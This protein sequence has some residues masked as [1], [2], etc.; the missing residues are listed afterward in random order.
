MRKTRNLESAN[1][2]EI[3]RQGDINRTKSRVLLSELQHFHWSGTVELRSGER[4]KRLHL[5]KGRVVRIQSN[6]SSE[7]YGSILETH[8]A[9]PR[10]DLD[11]ALRLQR[12]LFPNMKV[13]DILKNHLSER[14]PK[15]TELLSDE[16]LKLAERLQFVNSLIQALTWVSGSFLLNPAKAK[17]AGD[18]ALCSIDIS[19]ALNDLL[20]FQTRESLAVFSSL[21]LWPEQ[22]G[23]VALSRYALW[24][25]LAS[26]RTRSLS[27]VLL[28]RKD[29]K[30]YEIVVKQG[31]P[32]ILY[33]GTFAK[34]RQSIVVRH[35]GQDHEEF[36]QDQIFHL[37]S[38]TTGSA[39]FRS[40]DSSSGG[41]AVV[42]A[43]MEI[44]ESTAILPEAELS[45]DE[46]SSVQ[47]L[48]P[49]WRKNL[50][51]L[52]SWRR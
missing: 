35:A 50:L 44:V 21:P 38:F 19:E 18:S 29:Q 16:G 22:V 26:L 6:L 31:L 27:G 8:L 13:G 33:E 15:L 52:F 30:L 40:F 4:L 43:S 12:E 51:R 24:N 46:V 37:L 11:E 23:Q 5:V 39:Y 49:Q 34:P 10:A 45:I 1:I 9:V 41:G 14:R 7:L 20:D 47:G 25:I 2:A 36:F 48:V 17:E 28:I 32:M 3:S 42:P